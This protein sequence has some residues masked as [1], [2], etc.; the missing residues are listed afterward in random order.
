MTSDM[1]DKT[2]QVIFTMNNVEKLRGFDII[3]IINEV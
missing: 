1:L 2:E 3:Y